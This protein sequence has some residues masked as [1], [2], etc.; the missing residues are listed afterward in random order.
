[1]GDLKIQKLQC[2]LFDM[3]FDFKRD[4]NNPDEWNETH[5]QVIPNTG[6][7]AEDFKFKENPEP[8]FA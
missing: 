1:M 2:D 3:R 6:L 8:F 4:P 5:R 7:V